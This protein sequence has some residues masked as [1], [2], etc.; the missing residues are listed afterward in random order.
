MLNVDLG[1]FFWV[2][3]NNA[4]EQRYNEVSV[5]NEI[6]HSIFAEKGPDNMTIWFVVPLIVTDMIAFYG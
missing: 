2:Q 4:V 1:A 5:E 3:M 6:I